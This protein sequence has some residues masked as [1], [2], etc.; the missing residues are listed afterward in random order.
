MNEDTIGPVRPM[1]NIDEVNGK[2]KIERLLAGGQ[3]A[4]IVID[5]TPE[6]LELNGYYTGFSDN[7]TKY[8]NMLTP[9]QLSWEE[10]EKIKG[11]LTAK[12][13]SKKKTT[14]DRI[15]R[16]VNLEYLENLPQVTMGGQKY[17]IDAEKRERRAVSN[18]GRVMKF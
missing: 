5:I 13:K 10:L 6:G 11:R 1:F 16:E 3:S 15:E 9:V 17:Y 18:P 4:G 12:S 7:A 8:S 2:K 14:L